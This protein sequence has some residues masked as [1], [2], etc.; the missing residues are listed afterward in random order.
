MKLF[1]YNDH[2]D[3]PYYVATVATLRYQ[4][5]V[6]YCYGRTEHCQQFASITEGMIVGI[7]IVS[8]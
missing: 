7:S 8:V 1:F 2:S 3:A 6:T 4:H 5:N